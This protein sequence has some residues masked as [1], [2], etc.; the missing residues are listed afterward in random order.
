MRRTRYLV[1]F[2]PLMCSP[3]RAEMLTKRA[4][5]GARE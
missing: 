2:T 4:R 3:S 1:V 5:T